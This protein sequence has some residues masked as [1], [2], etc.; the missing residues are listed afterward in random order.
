VFCLR[1]TLSTREGPPTA[2]PATTPLWDL[3]H[4]YRDTHE[5]KYTPTRRA[6]RPSSGAGVPRRGA[7]RIGEGLVADAPL[8]I[9]TGLGKVGTLEARGSAPL[10][11]HPT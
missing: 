10:M 4:L 5:G 6:K 7:Y 1:D 11:R 9:A 3:P 2:P 8:T